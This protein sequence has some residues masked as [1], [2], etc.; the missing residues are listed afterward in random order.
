MSDSDH[1]PGA[2]PDR[3]EQFRALYLQEQRRA[4]HLS[5][6]N[7]V[8]KCAL[9]TRDVESFLPQVTRAIGSHFADCDVTLYLLGASRF[10]D[11]PG[12][13]HPPT[14]SWDEIE[15]RESHSRSANNPDEMLV[16]ASSGEHDLGPAPST[17]RVVWEWSENGENSPFHAEAKSFLSVPLTIQSESGGLIA[18]QSREADVLDA[19]DVGA[20]KTATAI[21][22]AHLQNGRLFRNMREINDF[23]QSLLN[24]ML[25]SLL[26]VDEEGCIQFVN[27]RL[28]QTFGRSRDALLKQPLESV[29]G[30]APARHHAL[31]EVISG[32]VESGQ[33][34]EVPEVHVRAPAGP[35]VF[36]VRMFRVYFRGQAEAAVLLINLTQRWRQ[37][38]RLQ[39][40]HEIGRLF[41]QS[42]DIDRV[43]L[44]VLT[45]ITAGSALGF[46]RAFV[47]LLDEKGKILE[48]RMA[49]GPS[50]AEEASRIWSEISQHE[51]TLPELLEQTERERAGERSPLQERVMQ[52]RIGLGNACFPAIERA[53]AEKTALS[54]RHD[55]L[56]KVCDCTEMQQ[57]EFE[58]A[59]AL[60]SAGNVAI[61]PLLAK[62]RLVGLV[63]A[64]NLYSG[65]E[66]DEGDVQLLDTLS[67]QAGLTIDNALAYEAL[68]RA[69]RELVSAERLVAVGEM[70][71]RV[72]HE[73]RNPL[74]TIGG[75]ARSA[76]KKT[77]DEAGVKRKIGVIVSEVAR[78]EELLTDLL[79]MARPRPLDFQPHS[80]NEIVEHSLLLADADIKGCGASV[81]RDLAPDLPPV[82]LDRGRL[83]QVLL[84]TI[85]NGAQAMPDGGTLRV[86]TRLSQRLGETTHM[87]EIEVRDSGVGIPS[88]AL[89]SVFD[90]FFSTK[91]SG[92]GLGLAV[93]KRIIQDHGGKIDVS[94]EEGVGTTFIFSLPLTREPV[95]HEINEP[96]L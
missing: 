93:T 59:A 52:L 10:G 56:L 7:E 71:A 1:A 72:S 58:A 44:S 55:E 66:I 70:A 62:D 2:L 50:S 24:S 48:G 18:V 90:P 25:H 86:A 80:V 82:P 94:S 47:F 14:S 57:S 61:A 88:R 40:M 34:H 3:E 85:R 13:A 35:Q 77:E 63:L 11:F 74:A 45:C 89:K 43:L 65:A 32:V 60:F 30:E 81:E 33:S 15:R 64:D 27:E 8:Q 29:F 91:V 54:V 75:F 28:C 5:L 16:V 69:Q 76:M 37:T 17:S 92:S 79:D 9:A 12:A 36:D 49:L 19:T 78:L 38:Y 87:V 84:N 68:Q 23:N 4:R 53:I 20:L 6:I 96:N 95:S 42:L 67:Q 83:L 31:R 51:L 46:N 21:I 26:V 39:L 22:A 73:I 41:Q